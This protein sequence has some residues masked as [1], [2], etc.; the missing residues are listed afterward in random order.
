[1][2]MEI[3]I[4][5]INAYINASQKAE[6]TTLVRHIKKFSKSG[7][8]IS[9]SEVLDKAGRKSRRTAQ[10]ILKR[11]AFHASAIKFNNNK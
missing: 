9:N 8:L 7:I 3:L 10:A 5:Y 4:L 1:M 6:L 2:E 11:Y